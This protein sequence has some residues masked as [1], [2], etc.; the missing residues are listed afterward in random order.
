MRISQFASFIA[1]AALGL[2]LGLL[3]VSA[4]NRVAL[5]VGN[6]KYLYVSPLENPVNDAKLLAAALRE[7][8]FTLIGD[9]PQL[10]LDKPALEAA[11]Q[12]FSRAIQGAEIALFYYAGHGVQVRGENYL[13]PVKADPAREADIDFHLTDANLVLR[14]MEHAGTKLNVVILDACRNNPFGGRGFRAVSRGLA[15]MLAPDSTLISYATQP[16]NVALDGKDGNSPYTK[17]LAQTIRRPGLDIF[18]M[19]N[20]VGLSVMQATG[21]SQQPWLSS[22]P[23]KGTFYFAR[24]PASGVP[25]AANAS[26]L[27]PVIALDP[28]AQAWAAAKDTTNPA[29]LEAFILRFS[30]TFYGD[31]A[32]AKLDDLKKGQVAV[33]PPPPVS[34]AVTPQTPSTQSAA[35]DPAD[36]AWATA[37]NSTSITVLEDFVR[38]Y[39]NTRYGALARARIEE[40]KK[41]QIAT[42]P[43]QPAPV[44]PPASADRCNA[45][46]GSWTMTVIRTTSVTFHANRT[47]TSGDWGTGTWSCS[48]GQYV[49]TWETGYVYRFTVSSNGASIA[50]TSTVGLPLSGTRVGRANA[51]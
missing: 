17:A 30:D 51:R 45:V 50:G 22:S 6:S 3:P 36:R 20:E 14:Q 35:V 49:L 5:V 15:R 31:M 21:N 37:Q 9:G 11:V 32:R 34:S 28:A 16:G 13:V 43:P 23:I 18:Q 47:V 1:A 4:Q 40:L 8:G 46:V 25:P 12:D 39:G 19:F 41:S 33:V 29:I 10:D 24:T 44:Q 2:L 42:L 26:P 27:A 7:L 48:N 38:Q